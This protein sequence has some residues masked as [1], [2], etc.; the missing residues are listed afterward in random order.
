MNRDEDKLQAEIVQ[1]YSLEYGRK[2]DKCLFLINNN[3]KKTIEVMR[4]KALG[5]KSGVADL[6]LI[7]PK[8]IIFV[9]LKTIKGV[10]GPDQKE[11]E[12][13]LLELEGEYVL[14]R[15]LEEFQLLCKKEYKY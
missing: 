4:L 2:H 10:Q 12:R 3:A 1:W 14:L 8:K 13:Q 11:F 7:V 15:S 6:G 5:L 9:E